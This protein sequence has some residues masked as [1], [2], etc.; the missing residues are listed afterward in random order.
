MNKR[1][2]LIRQQM[3]LN[4]RYVTRGTFKLPYHL[5]T[6]LPNVPSTIATFDSFPIARLWARLC[7]DCDQRELHNRLL[8][9]NSAIPCWL[10]CNCDHWTL[11]PLALALFIWSRNFW[12]DYLRPFARNTVRCGQL[13]GE[14]MK[15][16][17]NGREILS[18]QFVGRLWLVCSH[19]WPVL[20]DTS[21]S[22]FNGV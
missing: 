9:G 20:A 6:G 19:V 8:S 21:S 15:D 7:G 14:L 5:Y 17:L 2:A 3:Q 11:F 4:I 10:T 13:S 1:N 18:G 16:L 12:S 22:V